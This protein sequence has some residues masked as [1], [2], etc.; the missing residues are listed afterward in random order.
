[1]TQNAELMKKPREKS[2]FKKL[3]LIILVLFLI[4][5]TATAV[6]YIYSKTAKTTRDDV[7]AFISTETMPAAERFSFDAS[8]L[9]MEISIDKS[10]LWWLF[11][12]IDKEDIMGEIA[13][14]LKSNGFTLQSYG[15]DIT[16]KGILISTE[17]TYGDFLRLPLKL[18]MNTS[19]N[20][21]TLTISPSRVYLGKI[22]LPLEKFPLN[23]L[24]S[25]FGMGSDFSLDDYKFDIALSDWDLLPMFTNIYFKGNRMVMVFNLDESLFSHSVSA[26]GDN[27]DW[28]ADECTDCL[29]VLREY[30][31]KGALG[32]RFTRLVENFSSK[33]ESFSGFIAE[34]LAVSSESASK[35]YLDKNEPWLSRFMSEITDKSISDLHASLYNLCAERSSLFISLLDTLQASYNS[36]EFGIDE[37][38][39]TYKSKPFDLE[40][41]L[42][43]DWDQYSG[44]LDASSFRPVLIGAKNAYD[45]KTP[46]L[47]KITDSRDYI[48]YVDTLDGKFPIGFIVKMKDGTPVLKYYSVFIVENEKI[49]ITNRTVV[50]DNAEYESMRNNPL[51]PVWRD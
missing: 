15:L 31:E 38:G 41:Y 32:E 34:T 51:V 40:S 46:L 8:S 45:A 3:L 23:R 7:S 22:R 48:D 18:L 47:R 29:E 24:A 43:G 19:V 30:S 49:K 12:E 21:G 11:K 37:K 20:N 33:P 50:L 42:G 9:K 44:W 16:D 25:G 17:L 39:F 6:L 36:R 26:F 14:D 35:K 2:I 28:Y 13:D 1:M 27:L 10:D 4:I 5:I